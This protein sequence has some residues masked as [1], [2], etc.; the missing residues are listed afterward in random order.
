MAETFRDLLGEV[1]EC[2]AALIL[3]KRMGL[4]QHQVSLET[5][6]PLYFISKFEVGWNLPDVAKTLL[7]YYSGLLQARPPANTDSLYAGERNG[8]AEGER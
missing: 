7:E 2:E 5:G 6:L 3:R 4:T 1:S 8:H